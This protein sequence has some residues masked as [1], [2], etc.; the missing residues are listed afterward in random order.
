MPR[1]G[2][3]GRFIFGQRQTTFNPETHDACG[4]NALLSALNLTEE[5]ALLAVATNDKL[6]GK[7]RT[8][9]RRVHRVRFV[10]EDVLLLLHLRGQSGDGSLALQNMRRGDAEGE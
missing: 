2:R 8:F 1:G 10:P 4:W 5:A 9:V 3:R 6:G 7:L